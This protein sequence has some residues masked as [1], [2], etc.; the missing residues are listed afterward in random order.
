MSDLIVIED[1]QL[2]EVFTQEDGLKPF[3]D[4]IELKISEFEHDMST[5][6]SRKRTASLAASIS[7]T[8]TFLDGKGKDLV[9]GWKKKAKVVDNSRKAMRERLDELKK[10]AREPLTQF[11]A[12]EEAKI[13]EQAAKVAAEKLAREIEEAHEFGLLMNDKFD[14]EKQEAKAQA[15][16]EQKE[17][18]EAIK[19]EAAE[20]ARLNEIARQEAQAKAE[21]EELAKREANKRHVGQ[22]RK[23]AKEALMVHG[24]TEDQAKAI[25][26]AINSGEIPNVSIQY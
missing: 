25:V 21:A 4:E 19:K 2:M 22:V 13:R 3:I 14:M 6:T 16:R 26:L 7:K 10:I 24:I 23:A 5:A 18:E 20:Q 8:K 9:S 17:R 1:K 12:E 15:E 11:E